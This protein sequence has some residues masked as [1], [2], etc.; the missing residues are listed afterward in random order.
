MRPVVDARRAGGAGAA[1]SSRRPR[2][3][4]RGT[5]RAGRRR[6]RPSTTAHLART[7]VLERV[8]D[9]LELVVDLLVL[10]AWRL[11]VGRRR[12]RRRR[13]G[14]G[15][16]LGRRPLRLGVGCARP[17][18]RHVDGD[19]AELAGVEL[20]PR[21]DVA[22]RDLGPAVL[23]RRRR[24]AVADDDAHRQLGHLGHHRRGRGVLLL[25]ADDAL[26][27]L[28]HLGDASVRVARRGVRADVVVAV[29]DE[30][31]ADGGHLVPAARAC[32]RRGRRPGCARAA[33]AARAPRCDR[34][35]SIGAAASVA[36]S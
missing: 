8:G 5:G 26:G 19:P 30:R 14:D 10:L 36:S 24:D 4:R 29:G 32:P 15:D 27:V 11:D 16:L 21:G 20:D 17:V 7:G 33:A 28:E 23:P 3:R 9:G 31:V 6:R 13:V 34:P 12:R 22:R 18:G 1:P 35:A 25:E 2:R